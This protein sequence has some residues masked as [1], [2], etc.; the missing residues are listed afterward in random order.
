MTITTPEG[1]AMFLT[2]AHINNIAMYSIIRGSNYNNTRSRPFYPKI[3]RNRK[4]V[5]QIHRELGKAM[6]R[7]AFRKS[8]DVFFKLY[9]TIKPALKVAIISK[10]KKQSGTRDVTK[11]HPI[12]GI[13]TGPARLA[14]AIRFWAGGDPY[15][16]QQVFGISHHAHKP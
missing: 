16:L 6:F 5:R 12:N 1:V 13:I 8:L 3:K 10:S 4:S 14:C 7:R 9:A 2:Q 15:D 11:I